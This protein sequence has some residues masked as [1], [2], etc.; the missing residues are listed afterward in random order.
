MSNDYLATCPHCGKNHD[1]PYEDVRHHI[2]RILGQESARKRKDFAEH[3]QKMHQSA[4]P[5][6]RP[7]LHP[8][9]QAILDLSQKEDLSKLK[10]REIADRVE[11]HSK[12]RVTRVWQHLDILKKKGLL[13]VKRRT[14]AFQVQQI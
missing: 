1:I 11:I 13:D 8:K 2:Y 5:M 4:R 10:L 6:H 9:Q 14:P 12:D 3:M 7:T